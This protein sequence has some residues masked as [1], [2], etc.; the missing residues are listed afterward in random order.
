MD[1][2]FSSVFD[3]LFDFRGSKNCSMCDM[4]TLKVI[5]KLPETRA[6]QRTSIHHLIKRT[7]EANLQKARKRQI[8]VFQSKL[9][10]SKFLSFHPFLTI[11]LT[12]GGSKFFSMGDMMA[13]KVFK[14]LAETKAVYRTSNYDITDRRSGAKPQKARKTQNLVFQGQLRLSKFLSFSRCLMFGKI[15]VLLFLQK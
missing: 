13:C 4:I 15:C 7:S 11:I 14:R 3:E 8:L 5:K 12:S 2:F 6:A 1:L 10:L 9:R